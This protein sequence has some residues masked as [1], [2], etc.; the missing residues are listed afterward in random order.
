MSGT[1][2]SYNIKLSEAFV[3][4]ILSKL[5]NDE[6][7]SICRTDEN[8]LLIRSKL[9]ILKSTVTCGNML[10]KGALSGKIDGNMYGNMSLTCGNMLHK[11]SRRH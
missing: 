9:F 8:I 11:D 4:K 7:G 5:R 10:K 1:I 6:I 2:S 3:N